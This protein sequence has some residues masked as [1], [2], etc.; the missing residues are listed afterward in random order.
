MQPMIGTTEIVIISLVCLFLLAILGALVFLLL[1]ARKS[2]PAVSGKMKKCPFC[3][4]MIRDE[5]VVCRFC[6]RDQPVNS[7]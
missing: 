1:R 2:E 6:G 4:E 3:A 7:L 5:A